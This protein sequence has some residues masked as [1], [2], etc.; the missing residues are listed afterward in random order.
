MRLQMDL[1]ALGQVQAAPKLNEEH[2]ARRI[3][4]DN[5]PGTLASAGS[6]AN[7]QRALGQTPDP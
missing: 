4:G 3:L 5:H 7:D 2:L 6:L 1:Y